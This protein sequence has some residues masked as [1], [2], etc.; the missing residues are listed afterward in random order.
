MSS[1]TAIQ[2]TDS[3]WS[4]ITGC[5]RISPGCA[6]CYAEYWTATRLKESPKYRGLAVITAAGQ[7]HWTGEIRLHEDE[8]QKPLH[9]KRPRRIFVNSMSDTFHRDVPDEFLDLMFA[10]MA[11]CPQH[12]FQVLTKRADRMQR[13]WNDGHRNGRGEHTANYVVRNLCNFT[14]DIYRMDEASNLGG[15]WPPNVQAGVSVENQAAADE[16]IPLLLQTPAAV[17]WLSMEPLLEP[18]DLWQ[19]LQKDMPRVDWVV[20]GC[21]SGPHARPMGLD[22][23]ARSIRYQ[24]RDAGVPFFMKQLSVR[25]RVT[26]NIDDF[27]K[28]LRIREYPT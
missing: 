17:R 11:L 10:V 20:V 25:G 27:P 23:G 1:K 21:E 18:V 2:W 3:T 15:H 22:W 13:Y 26:G 9:W 12:Q 7:P 4:T 6:N 8:L 19:Y 16:R 5:E 28:D 14:D 24:C